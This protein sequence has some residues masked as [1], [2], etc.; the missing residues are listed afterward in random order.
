MRICRR[1]QNPIQQ[2]YILSYIKRVEK[3]NKEGRKKKRKKRV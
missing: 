2:V 3:K 1:H